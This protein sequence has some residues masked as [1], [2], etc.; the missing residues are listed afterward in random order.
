[1]FWRFFTEGK[2]CLLRISCFDGVSCFWKQIS[3]FHLQ[4][5][6]HS[7]LKDWKIQLRLYI[8][9]Y[10]GSSLFFLFFVT[11]LN[12]LWSGCFWSH[13]VRKKWIAIS[14]ELG[15]KRNHKREILGGTGLDLNGSQKQ[16]EIS[17]FFSANFL[18]NLDFLDFPT[19]STQ[20]SPGKNYLTFQ[21]LTQ[22]SKLHQNY[23]LWGRKFTI[24]D[25]M[26]PPANRAFCWV[27]ETV[28]TSNKSCSKWSS[29]TEVFY[30]TPIDRKRGWHPKKTVC[31]SHASRRIDWFSQEFRAFFIIWAAK[32]RW[33][34][35][36]FCHHHHFT[37]DRTNKPH[38][39]SKKI[40]LTP[41]IGRN[42]R[43]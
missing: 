41:K 38:W 24:L 31:K 6:L 12:Q 20:S 25:V 8:F 36:E 29:V 7:V 10:W 26:T 9:L 40:Y 17:Y 2:S 18:T 27:I 19:K 15:S 33:E 1:M 4:V 35:K 42:L 3:Q 11:A 13:S 5:I 14:I 34:K 21:Q 37:D 16:I 28:E 32:K 43:F 23:G 30:S 22:P 39:F